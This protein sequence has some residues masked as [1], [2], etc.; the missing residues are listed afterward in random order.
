MRPCLRQA[1]DSNGRLDARAA[2]D[3]YVAWHGPINTVDKLTKQNADDRIIG[4]WQPVD[5]VPLFLG[6]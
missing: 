6:R 2:I 1:V 3:F 5:W 4:D